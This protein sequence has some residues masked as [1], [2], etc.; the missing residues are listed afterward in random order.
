MGNNSG[1]LWDYK[2]GNDPVDP[3]KLMGTWDTTG[4]N[5][6]TIVHTYN[7]W[8]PSSV[9]S[10]VVIPSTATPGAYSFCTAQN[11]AEHVRAFVIT[12]SSGCSGVYP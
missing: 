2:L 5:P 10:W 7:A 4:G 1:P 3:R 8:S 6:A 11:G 9:F 12:S